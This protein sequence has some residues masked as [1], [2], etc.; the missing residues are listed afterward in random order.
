MA[1][2]REKLHNPAWAV[3]NTPDS[4]T[5]NPYPFKVNHLEEDGFGK[6]RTISHTGTTAANRQVR[7][8]AAPDPM[9]FTL[10][11]SIL[12]KSQHDQFI[13]FFNA[14]DHNTVIFTDFEGNQYEVLI[15]DY[16]PTRKYTIRN[17]RDPSI[18]LHYYSYT[19]KMEVVN[20]ISGE[21]VG[22]NP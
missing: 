6:T 18:P 11:G 14:C 10:T 13:R 19:L 7:Q 8:Q 2:G 15:I 4:P 5:Q 3:D 21:W 17:P 20:F 22:T 12:H 1:Y 9:T 16:T